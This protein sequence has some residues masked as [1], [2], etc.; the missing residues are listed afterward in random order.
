M[1]QVEKPV[2]VNEHKAHEVSGKSLATLRND[3]FH[4]R[5]IP[6]YKIGGLVRY[7]LQDI[8]DF[9]ESHRITF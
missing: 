8:Y 9:M 1:D 4:R 7:K 6:Y 5:G 3:R 2:Y